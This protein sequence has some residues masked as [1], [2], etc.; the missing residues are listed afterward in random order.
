MTFSSPNALSG[1][2]ISGLTGEIEFRGIR[3]G[4]KTETKSR[5]PQERDG[6]ADW[7]DPSD[8]WH[9]RNEAAYERART[10]RWH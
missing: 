4:P 9:S 6:A 1:V 10:G 2:F 3:Q 5:W 7:S 8:A